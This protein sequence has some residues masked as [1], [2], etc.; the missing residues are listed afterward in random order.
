[1]V[2]APAG[3]AGAVVAAI[4]AA[5]SE[6]DDR[7]ESG[8]VGSWSGRAVPVEI[9][10]VE[11][12]DVTEIGLAAPTDTGG[13]GP[14][15][16]EASLNVSVATELHETPIGQLAELVVQVVTA[17]G[18]I[19][20]EEVV[21]RIRTAWGLQRAGGRIQAAVERGVDVAVQ[22]GRVVRDDAFLSVPGASV[23][24]RDRSGV[25]SPSLRRPDLLPPV[26]I[27]AALLQVIRVGLGATAEEAVLGVSRI[28]GFKAT[29]AQLKQMI[30]KAL[31]ALCARG[32]LIQ[33]SGILVV[34]TP[35]DAG[36]SRA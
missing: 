23:P 17:E 14:A 19:H 33:Q 35:S 3:A 22:R 27:E 24:V 25:M 32:E 1:L 34:A 11:R 13:A 18:P 7:L 26:E 8:P 29:S 28:M 5:K 6:L 9:V 12:E 21:V 2:P 4:A 30:G 20:I 16:R 15:Y 10:T 36:M 31:D